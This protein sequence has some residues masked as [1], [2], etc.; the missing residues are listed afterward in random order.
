MKDLKILAILTVIVLIT[1]IGIEPFAHHEMH[2]T[3]PE[4]DYNYLDLPKVELSGNPEEGK[5]LFKTN[6]ASCHGVQ[7][8][9]I[10]PSMDAKTAELSFKVVPP[11]LS[12][13][14]SIIEPHFFASFVKDPQG[15]T[16]FPKFAMPGMSYLTKE[17]IGNIYAYL[18]SV[19]KPLDKLT[20][21]EIL[22]DACTR[23]HSVRYQKIS[24]H[25]DKDYLNDYLGKVP[26]DLSLMGKAK[27]HEYLLA[28]INNPQVLLPGTSMPRL[29]LK[30]ESA[31][32]I[33]EYLD[34][35]SDPHKEERNKVGLWVLAYLFVLAGLAYGWKKKIWK[36]IH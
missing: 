10:S 16:K 18:K 9:G 23:C 31:V 30:E 4:P 34:E 25:T 2:G 24:A 26:P 12:N 13:I 36:N 14:T 22:E 33:V 6:C 1:Y 8:D 35:I 7:A 15:A 17:Q 19:A 20:G 21:K 27:E 5:K 28:F 3:V 29:G 11:D 32:K